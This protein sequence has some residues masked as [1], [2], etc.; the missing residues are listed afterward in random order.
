LQSRLQ[1]IPPSTALE[2]NHLESSHV[3]GKTPYRCIAT[4]RSNAVLPT[5]WRDVFP[6]L[7]GEFVM[8]AHQDATHKL[9]AHLVN[10]IDTQMRGNGDSPV[11]TIELRDNL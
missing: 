6:Y 3:T 4:A 10:N 7:F 5:H 1:I 8:N 11:Q 2:F 9:H